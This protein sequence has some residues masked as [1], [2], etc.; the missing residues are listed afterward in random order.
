[1][2]RRSGG[3]FRECR[4]RLADFLTQPEKTG[5]P[6]VSVGP[7]SVGVGSRKPDERWYRAEEMP[8]ISQ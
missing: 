3:G 5:K 1:V 4:N 8:P 2:L 7:Q 6:A